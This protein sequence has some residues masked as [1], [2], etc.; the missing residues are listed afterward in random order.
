MCNGLKFNILNSL[1]ILAVENKISLLKVNLSSE[2]IAKLLLIFI[3]IVIFNV[4]AF[5]TVLPEEP[6][7][8]NINRK[9]NL[10]ISKTEKYSFI[11][12]EVMTKE[13]CNDLYKRKLLNDDITNKNE[14]FPKSIQDIFK[15]TYV[16]DIFVSVCQH[17]IEFCG[18]YFYIMHILYVY[19]Y[20]MVKV[21][22][23]S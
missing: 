2:F 15:E 20:L 18:K 6:N 9:E 7:L 11:D 10:S 16:D 5:E 14:H 13:M 3:I 23:I 12:C 4:L 21:Q 19:L 8:S 1:Y 17:M 22:Y